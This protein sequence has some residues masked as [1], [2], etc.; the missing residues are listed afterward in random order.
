MKTGRASCPFCSTSAA[1]DANDPGSALVSDLVTVDECSRCSP[2]C[3]VRAPTATSNP[4]CARWM[5]IAFPMPRL[6]PVTSATRLS[7]ALPELVA[8]PYD[9]PHVSGGL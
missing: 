2:S 7:M 4:A 6:A 3:I 1:V 8:I 5:A 9:P